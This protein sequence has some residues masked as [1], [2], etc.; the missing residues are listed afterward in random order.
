MHPLTRERGSIRVASCC[1]CVVDCSGERRGANSSDTVSPSFLYNIMKGSKMSKFHDALAEFG[2]AL[3]LPDEL[4]GKLE[5]AYDDD[6]SNAN[7]KVNSLESLISEK[8]AAIEKWQTD[9]QTQ[10]SA[11]KAAQ[12]DLLRAGLVTGSKQNETDDTN[13]NIGDGETNYDINVKD[14]FRPRKA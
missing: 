9:F 10:V 5:S 6:F 3:E 7:E 2:A 13:G 8:D 4:R 11:T 14:L 12:F 1:F